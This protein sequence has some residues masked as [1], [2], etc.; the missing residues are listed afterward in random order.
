LNYWQKNLIL[1]DSWEKHPQRNS[2]T[3]NQVE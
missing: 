2:P 1:L 3:R